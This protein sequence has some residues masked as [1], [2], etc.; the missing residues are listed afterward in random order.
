MT[1]REWLLENFD[2]ETIFHIC[3]Y[4]KRSNI[5]NCLTKDNKFYYEH[6]DE[7]W[8]VLNEASACHHYSTLTWLG[9]LEGTEY[10]DDEATFRYFISQIA[11]EVVAC[12]II[13]EKGGF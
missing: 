13:R 3:R 4:D 8:E 10:V 9:S 5:K 11:I 2:Q 7:I 6:T 1:I 12:S